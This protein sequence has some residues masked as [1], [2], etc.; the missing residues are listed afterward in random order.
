MK[1]EELEMINKTGD[2]LHKAFLIDG[3]VIFRKFITLDGMPGT[4][5]ELTDSKRGKFFIAMYRES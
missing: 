4:L 3:D 1:T 5:F 2:F